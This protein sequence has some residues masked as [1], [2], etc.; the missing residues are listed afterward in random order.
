MSKQKNKK[1]NHAKVAGSAPEAPEISVAMEHPLRV[2]SMKFLF[3]SML[4]FGALLYIDSYGYFEPDDNNNHTIKKWNSFYEFTK[5]SNVDIVLIGNSHLYTGINPKNLSTALGLNA[6]ILASPGTNTADSYYALKEALKRCTPSVVVMETY[7]INKFEPY[8]IKAGLLS[9]QFKSFAARRDLA[10]KLLST[11]Y[12]FATKNYPYAW[13]YT[14]R[15]HDY[16]Y[17]NKEQIERNI[18]KRKAKKEKK[19]LYLGRFV[20]FQTG[21]KDSI[22]SLY[23]SLG[24]PVDGMEY[25]VN[26][27]T[28]I[29]TNK[30]IQIC[31]ENDIALIFLTLPMYE[32]HIA[33]Y[34]N[35][36]D[37]LRPLLGNYADHNWIDMQ[38]SVGY[39]GFDLESFE[40]TY[41]NNQHMTYS[42]SLLATYKLANFI[43]EDKTITLPNRSQDASWRRTFYGVEGF[44]ENHTPDA[45]DSTAILLY[46]PDASNTGYGKVSEL[47]HIRKKK[48]QA[49]V[50]KVPI[51]NA[52][53]DYLKKQELRLLIMYKDEKGQVLRSYVQM[54]YDPFHSTSY[55]MNFRQNLKKLEILQILKMEFSG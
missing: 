26:D 46:Q 29:Y 16:L 25:E 37:K 42:G 22:L 44:Y 7:G 51:E 38:D 3:L 53:F 19:R 35:W 52:D 2:I 23:D 1:G 32:K 8:K 47:L 49:V 17:N 39:E 27:Q 30:I 12:L 55:R 48:Y 5:R 28:E 50:A 40:N 24:A 41:A 36:R 4:V 11:P 14:L 20:R 54:K 33:N 43:L 15:N 34:A 13:S 18:E 45:N 6:F 31:E 9:D 10:I 21:I